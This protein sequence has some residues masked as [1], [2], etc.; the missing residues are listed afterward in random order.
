MP[1]RH[2]QRSLPSSNELDADTAVAAGIGAGA[3]SVNVVA[4]ASFA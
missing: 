4:R 3:A 2:R 1:R